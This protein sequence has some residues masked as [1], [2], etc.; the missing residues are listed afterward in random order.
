M[1]V[2]GMPPIPGNADELLGLIHFLRSDD[3]VERVKTLIAKTEEYNKALE[4]FEALEEISRLV[5][6]AHETNNRAVKALDYANEEA[7]NIVQ[8]AEQEVAS[9]RSDLDTRSSSLDDREEAL[10]EREEALDRRQSALDE[11]FKDVEAREREADAAKA[12][13]NASKEHYENLEAGV[14][15]A[16]NG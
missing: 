4:G 3:F 6:E 11:A 10:N 9:I 1:A 15:Q 12:E 7:T 16:M 13:A 5:E 8:R 2:R 14:R